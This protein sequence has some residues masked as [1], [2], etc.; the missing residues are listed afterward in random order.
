[1]LWKNRERLTDLSSALAHNYPEIAI[2]FH[3]HAALRAAPVH[4]G[5]VLLYDPVTHSPAALT[6]ANDFVYK[7]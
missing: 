4:L 3:L 6:H 1:M 5:H 2:H 7:E